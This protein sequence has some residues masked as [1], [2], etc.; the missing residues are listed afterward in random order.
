MFVLS[1][2]INLF[3]GSKKILEK[4]NITNAGKRTQKKKS[5]INISFP[6]LIIILSN[7]YFHNFIWSKHK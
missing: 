4:E 3:E 5:L 6:V 7:V 1:T 2:E